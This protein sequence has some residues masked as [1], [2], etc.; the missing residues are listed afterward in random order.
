VLVAVLYAGQDEFHL[1]LHTGR[2]LTHSVYTRCSINTIVLLRM[3]TG[4]FETCRG[5]K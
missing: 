2:P 3:G 5:F 1:D 4:L